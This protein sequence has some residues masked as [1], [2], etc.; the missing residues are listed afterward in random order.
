M[1]IANILSC[2]RIVDIYRDLKKR[3]A[4]NEIKKFAQKH[5]TWLHE[6][7]YYGLLLFHN[8]GLGLTRTK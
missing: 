2:I 7:G 5:E 3:T 6:D 4:I 8:I 1:K